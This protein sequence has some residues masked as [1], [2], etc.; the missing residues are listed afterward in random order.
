MAA[1]AKAGA[2]A[3]GAGLHYVVLNLAGSSLFLIAVG[4]LYGLFGTLNM[5][6]L[7]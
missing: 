3:P 1:A 7:A 4:T 6:D 2:C 5:A